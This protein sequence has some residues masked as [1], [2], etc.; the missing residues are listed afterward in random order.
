VFDPV[1]S[2]S[3]KTHNESFLFDIWWSWS[4]NGTVRITTPL[5]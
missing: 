1:V 4:Q 3:T 2:M 5:K